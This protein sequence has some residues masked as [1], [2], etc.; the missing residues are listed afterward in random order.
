MVL[1]NFGKISDQ[2][3]KTT[4]LTPRLN[5]FQNQPVLQALDP[6]FNFCNLPLKMKSVS[7]QVQLSKIVSAQVQVCK[8]AG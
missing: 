8:I 3:F 7:V 6:V 4:I 2:D 5:S 1:P